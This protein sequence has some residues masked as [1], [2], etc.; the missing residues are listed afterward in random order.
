MPETVRGAILKST[1]KRAALGLDRHILIDER[2]LLIDVALLA[3]EVAVGRLRNCRTVPV[4][5]GLWQSTHCIKPWLTAVVIRFGEICVGR[6]V[7]LVTQLRLL[8]N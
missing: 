6:G 4:P 1:P 2:T 3:N 8:L 7:A 5:C